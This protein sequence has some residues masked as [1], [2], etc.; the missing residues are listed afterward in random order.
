MS[1]LVI[2]LFV[3][4]RWCGVCVAEELSDRMMR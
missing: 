4:L 1:C 3:S 2:K